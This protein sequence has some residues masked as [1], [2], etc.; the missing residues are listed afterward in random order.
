MEP[1]CSGTSR[2]PHWDILSVLFHTYKI[3]PMTCP[4][5]LPA[6]YES[7]PDI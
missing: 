7:R 6:A 4:I 5:D 3:G 2:C 1:K